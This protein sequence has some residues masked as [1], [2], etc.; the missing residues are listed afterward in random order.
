M[1]Y[2]NKALETGFFKSTNGE[3]NIAYYVYK[4]LS[5]PRAIVQIVHGMCE[6]CGRYED[7][8]SFLCSNGIMVCCHDHLGHGA[9]AESEEKLGFFANERGWQYLAKDTVRLSR[10]IRSRNPGVP[11]Y[12]LGHSM[13]SL[14]V[15]TVLAKYDFLYNGTIIMGTL[16]TKVAADAGIVLTRA[17]CKAKGNFYR[18][19]AVD[20]LM[21]GLSNRRID[22]PASE[23]SWISR[24]EDIVSEYEKNPLCNFHFTVRAYSDL[25]FLVSYVSDKSWVKKLD[26][27]LPIF[28]CSGSDDPVGNYGKGPKEVFDA[29]DSAGFSDI[30][31]KIY[32]GAR[33]EILNETNRAEVYEDIL[34]WLN[35]R[36][37][38]TD[39][40]A[41]E[42]E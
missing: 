31:L 35:N 36:I 17:I 20:Q 19:E 24:D 4:P 14:V 7:F 30:E 15:R 8:I 41:Y 38:F 29:L 12:I 9:S 1:N 2:I 18:S 13:G 32:S 37:E 10:M 5:E 42:E 40:N 6:Y 21:F 34:G 16:N 33:H 25:L 26:K 3:D 22:D 39:D 28:I 27:S 23:Y 11:F